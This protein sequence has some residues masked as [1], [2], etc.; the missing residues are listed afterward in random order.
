MAED[1][2]ETMVILGQKHTIWGVHDSEDPMFQF[3]RLTSNVDL[4]AMPTKT[5]LLNVMCVQNMNDK[6]PNYE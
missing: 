4:K 2:H 5:Q 6:L 3:M 1:S